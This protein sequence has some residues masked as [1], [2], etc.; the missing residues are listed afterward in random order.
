M[1]Q[2]PPSPINV[3]SWLE[4]ELYSQYLND[5]RAVDEEWNS[6]FQNRQPN[7]NG[8]AATYTNGNTSYAARPALEPPAPK[9]APAAAPPPSAPAGAEL[10]LLKGAAKKIAENM[11]V[12]LTVPTASS[13]RVIPVKVIEENRR[14]LNQHRALHGQSKISFTHLVAWAI[15]KALGKHENLNNAYAEVDGQPHRL[16]RKEINL[17]IAVDVA[18]K[19]G[20]RSLVVPNIKN[21]G[22]LNF[23]E[24]MRVFEDL[25]KRARQG[26]LMP[27]DFEGTTI[28]L[29]NP[30]TV[31]TFGSAPR[32]MAGQGAIIATGV[33]D[34]PAGYQG[35]SE[36][37]RAQIG[38]SKIMAIT[39]TYDH[40]IIQGAES[41]V[42]LA[43][44]EQ[45]L[46]GEHGFYSRMFA[47]LRLPYH[48]VRWEPDRMPSI[49]GVAAGGLHS[50]EVAKQA[51]VLQLINAYRV[52]GHLIAD[53]DPLGSEPQY[54][55]ELD[56]ATY[57]LTIWDLDREFSTGTLGRAMGEDGQEPQYATLRDILE[58]LRSTYCGKIGCEYMNIQHPEQKRWLQHHM[59]PQANAWPLDAE[60]KKRILRNII[61]AEEFEHFLHS[62]F[63]GQK[64]FALE[65]SESAMAILDSLLSMGADRDVQEVVMG[66]AH[67][68]R[69]TVLANLIGKPLTQIFSAFEGE[70]DPDATQG[71]G[72][73]KYHLGAN[74][75][76]QSPTGREI[77][78]SLSPNPSHLEA[79]NPVVE[80]IARP[81]QDRI[82][83]TWRCKVIPVLVH[84]DAAFAGQG[85]VAETLNIS[86]LEGYTTGGTIHLIINNQIGFTTNPYESRSTHYCTDVA[87][88]VQAPIFHVN[89]DDPEACVRVAELAFQYRQAFKKDVVI[90]MF[91]YRRHGHNEGDDPSYT[92]PV[93]YRKIKN[94]PS[95]VKLY[96]DRLVRE[97]VLSADDVTALQKQYLA[98]LSAAFDAAQV[99]SEEFEVQE[100]G[101]LDA[102]VM[103]CPK[104]AIDQSA[105]ERVIQGITAVPADFTIHPKL[106]NFLDKRKEVL[107][108]APMDWATAE[109]IAFGSLLLEGTPV[110][111]SG[112]DSARGTFTQRHLELYDYDSG[113]PYL[114]MKNISPDQARFDV[115]DSALSEFAVMGF[116]FGYSLGDP[117]TLVMWEGQFGDFVNGAQVMIDQF[118]SAAESKWGQPSGL[119]LLL[120]HG[121]EGQGPEHSSARIERFL[122]LCAE[123]NMQVCNC[124]TPAQYFHLLRRQMCGGVDRRGV[125][126]PLIIFTPK[127]ML[128]HP[129]AVSRISDLTS[130]T[131][132]EVIPDAGAPEPVSRLLLCSGKLYWELLAA[133]EE[134]QADHVGIVRV[135][136]MYPFPK[137][138]IAEQLMRY[139]PHA[140]VFWVQEEPKNM[141]PWRFMQ[142]NL[143]PMLEPSR[144]RLR[145]VGRVESASPAT[146]SSKRH[147]AEQAE[148]IEAS[149]SATPQPPK[150]TRMVRK[151]AKV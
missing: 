38:I 90:D 30:G 95:V 92:Q 140:E 32:L 145:Y 106:K 102:G 72:D 57:G 130:G 139:T 126:K 2:D 47:D 59:E 149:F 6:V 85:V 65:G 23:E 48:P 8:S 103:V 19:D 12:S 118:I 133:K 143:D 138:A 129:R 114:P 150:R 110:R 71:S 73:V 44:L 83:D 35:V 46:Q 33:I 29:T 144:R 123:N 27:P 11:E 26:K 101:P 134:R 121:Y 113:R 15:V 42:F 7:G 81:K 68:G 53:F 69:L 45:L 142:E 62:R 77:R 135:E 22:A 3:N 79:V 120:P 74:G 40:R 16:L 84:G 5:R 86:Q 39:C 21:A 131:F 124:T 63:R 41:G 105:I 109:A 1:A 14:I 64:R 56:P 75:L 43:T 125:R 119:V 87:R 70:L 107:N 99:K 137:A 20:N 94:Q 55:A 66:M 115:I 50:E 36:A 91:C 108:G 98:K 82:G 122:Q 147:A 37:V 49:S 112:Q 67:R 51:A 89:G 4:D 128:R 34:Y 146:G 100:I 111:L 96:S 93:M 80:G 78:V 58:T 148:I 88:T 127:S 116:E 17:G 97:K 61:E 117:L 60:Q 132:L 136:Q 24:Y 104:T 31:G 18:G 52:R 10:V 141:G 151:R 13:Q 25:V 76:H 9:P 28:S 54:H